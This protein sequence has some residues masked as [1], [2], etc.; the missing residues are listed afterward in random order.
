MIVVISFLMWWFRPGNEPVYCTLTYVFEK[1]GDRCYKYPDGCRE[2]EDRKEVMCE[3]IRE[4]SRIVKP[5][6][7]VKAN[8]CR[9]GHPDAIQNEYIVRIKS[10]IFTGLPE[11][12]NIRK[13]AYDLLENAKK[14]TFASSF[15]PDSEIYGDIQADDFD[16][17]QN[18][19]LVVQGFSARLTPAAAES[20]RRSPLVEYIV[21]NK[22]GYFS[23][24]L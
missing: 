16:C 22:R 3:G 6:P 5:S 19:L 12:S 11:A 18:V 2:P 9:N 17:I 10:E 21:K 14:A 4:G 24:N 15:E 7:Q 1:D 13:V 23:G 20:I 8:K